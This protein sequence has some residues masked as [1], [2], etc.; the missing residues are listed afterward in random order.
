MTSGEQMISRDDRYRRIGSSD[1]NRAYCR[2]D[3]TCYR[4]V[5]FT[6]AKAYAYTQG[7][8]LISCHDFDT[9]DTSHYQWEV[10]PGG[11]GG[12]KPPLRHSPRMKHL[13][14]AFARWL[15]DLAWAIDEDAMEADFLD[16]ADDRGWTL[17]A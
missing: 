11:G 12:S 16:L 13:R 2:W 6:D 1:D 9:S 15:A 8:K 10:G 17:G 7:G 5:D 4:V 14:A 3:G